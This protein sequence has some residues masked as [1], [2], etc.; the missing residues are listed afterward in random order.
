[1]T[2]PVLL[3]VAVML[4]LTACANKRNGNMAGQSDGRSHSEGTGGGMGMEGKPHLKPGDP[5]GDGAIY[6]FTAP[7]RL[8]T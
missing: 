2:L 5:P 7:V 8:E 1:M 3:V 4:A 6:S